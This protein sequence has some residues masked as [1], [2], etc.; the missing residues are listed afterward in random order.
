M[1][2]LWPS[3]FVALAL[4]P[5]LILLYLWGQRSRRRF[6][7]RYSSL[8]LV[9][10]A[11]PKQSRLRRYLPMALLFLALASLVLSLARPVT[12]MQVPAGRATVMLVLDV[13]SSMRQDDISPSRMVAAQQAALGFID[14]QKDTNQVGIVAFAS[15]A[16]LVQ[17]PTT[18][19]EELESTILGL[20]T[21][22]GTA[23]GEGVV[24]ALDTI[25]EFGQSAADGAERE[26]RAG[27]T[28][29]PTAEDEYKPDI[30]VL[31]TDGNYNAGID[32]LEAAQMAAD[33]GVRVYTIGYGTE[34]GAMG[35]SAMGRSMMARGGAFGLDEASLEAIASTTGGEYYTA[36][37]AGELQEVFDSLPTALITRE[38][39]L[40]IS[41]IAAA[42]AALLVIGA[43]LLSQ[44]WHPLP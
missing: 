36:R 23:I 14:K 27:A 9:R 25:A 41:V 30:I 12:V 39:T 40:E 42:V 10:A 5:L 34:A 33:S 37:S 22:R 19:P 15:I 20:T 16:Q 8:S 21:G 1:R 18:D 29:T 44:R 28:A 7:V 17:A 4:I 31:L 13:S 11:L 2:F 3:A 26:I 6:A 24:T 32:P 43:V 38:E 35:W